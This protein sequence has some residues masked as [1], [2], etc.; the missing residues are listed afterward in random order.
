MPIRG[1][2]GSIVEF[3]DI[4]APLA[5]PRATGG[6]ATDAVD[7]VIPSLTGHALSGPVS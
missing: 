4:I 6:T 2:P 5:D 7:L 1:W 3:V